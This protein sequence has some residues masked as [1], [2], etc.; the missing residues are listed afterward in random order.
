LITGERVTP[1]IGAWEAKLD[2]ID[3]QAPITGAARGALG[4]QVAARYATGASIRDLAAEMGRSYGFVHR[5]LVEAQVTL[6]DRGGPRRAAKNKTPGT[7]R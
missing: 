1:A 7:Q 6:R 2:K 5:L 4:K 3:K